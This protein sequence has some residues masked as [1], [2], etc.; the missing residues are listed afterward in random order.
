[1]PRKGE[2]VLVP[3]PFTDLS[4]QKLRPAL[5][6]ASGKNLGTNVVVALIST[7][8]KKPLPLYDVLLDQNSSGFKQTGLK[9][10]SVIKL[11]RI[12]TLNRGIFLGELGTINSPTQVEVAKRLKTLFDF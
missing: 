1:M 5:V 7:N 6:L 12:A 9:I 4:T 8:I 11:D 2:I 3:F 10:T